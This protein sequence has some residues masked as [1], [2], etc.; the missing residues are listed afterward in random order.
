MAIEGFIGRPGWGAIGYAL[1]RD[2]EN[3]A[4]SSTSPPLV[5]GAAVLGSVVTAG[6]AMT[7]L[8]GSAPAIVGITAAMA[9]A[10]VPS[11]AIIAGLYA[12]GQ[13]SEEKYQEAQ[14][15]LT[16]I[17]SPEGLVAATGLLIGGIPLNDAL[18]HANSVSAMRSAAESAAGFNTATTMS[19]GFGVA[20]GLGSAAD[21]LLGGGQAA[22]A[23]VKIPQSSHTNGAS[24]RFSLSDGDRQKGPGERAMERNMERFAT[25][26]RGNATASKTGP[27]QDSGL[28][29]S[30]PGNGEI[31]NSQKGA[32]SPN[33]SKETKKSSDKN[34]E[35]M[36]KIRLH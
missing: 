6:L 19:E 36:V 23:N 4:E 1:E 8:T 12:S 3:R 25:K 11:V 2:F 30:K 14:A 31:N 26:D 10:V 9:I 22:S 33:A 28:S 7:A 20:A 16:G 32:T 13:I 21:A 35:N 27:S 17:S 15:L 5:G 18:R 24:S 29:K 34:L